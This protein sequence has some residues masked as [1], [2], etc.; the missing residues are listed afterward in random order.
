MLTDWEELILFEKPARYPKPY[1]QTQG[2]SYQN[3][4]GGFHRNRT[5]KPDV[6]VEAEKIP[7]NQ[8]NLE[9]EEKAGGVPAPDGKLC[10]QAIAIKTESNR[11]LDQWN[12]IER[13]EINPRI[14][15]QLIY[16]QGAQKGG[17]GEKQ[18]RQML[19]P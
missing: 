13:P 1:L 17:G 11:H 2:N 9:K 6:C 14:Y 3:F 10:H 4:D 19:T 12:R 8:S 16:D 15:S 18:E 7:K 5:N